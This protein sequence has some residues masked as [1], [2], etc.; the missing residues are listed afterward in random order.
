MSSSKLFWLF[1]SPGSGKTSIAHTVAQIFDEHHRLAGCFFCDSSD[2]DRRSPK[3]IMPTIAYQLAKWHEDYRSIILDILQ[4]RGEL[5]IYAGI[6]RQF[7][8]LVS[9]PISGSSV[10]L[11]PKHRPLI[12]V[13]DALDESCDSVN[14]RR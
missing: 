10:R 2:T 13:L 14:S 12:I 1:G 3:A 11:P 5:D 6:Q 8:L 9:Q 4:S 7:D